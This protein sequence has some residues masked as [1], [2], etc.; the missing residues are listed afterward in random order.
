[1][2]CNDI[3]I[4]KDKLEV[5]FHLVNAYNI[6]KEEKI[7]ALKDII[8][9]TQYG[10]FSKDNLDKI[11]N[12]YYLHSQYS[13]N[14][15]NYPIIKC[16]KFEDTELILLMIEKGLDLEMESKYFKNKLFYQPFDNKLPVK[17]FIDDYFT[18]IRKI[19]KEES[20]YLLSLLNNN[21][22]KINKNENSFIETLSAISYHIPFYSGDYA[23]ILSKQNSESI[24]EHFLFN[25]H[26]S[27]NIKIDKIIS[28][29]LEEGNL[30]VILSILKNEST[31]NMVIESPSFS[32]VNIFIKPLSNFKKKSYSNKTRINEFLKDEIEHN[33]LAILDNGCLDKVD[34]SKNCEINGTNVGHIGFVIFNKIDCFETTIKNKKIIGKILNKL[35]NIDYPNSEGESLLLHAVRKYSNIK[36]AEAL[37]EYGA[38]L[39]FK[40]KQGNN[41][42]NSHNQTHK[43]M[44]INLEKEL[45]LSATENF[46]N[47]NDH[48][49]NKRI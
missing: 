15:E 27:S 42:F 25:N 34:F 40:D 19:K 32:L 31:R 29:S 41:I 44:I 1:M 14:T 2:E 39:H 46:N 48:K 30:S 43:S 22:H 13:S 26:D 35:P 24:S 36:I 5:I 21:I 33:I 47:K 23:K 17:I 45:I 18:K 28:N 38:D 16:M 6:S 12:I 4:D 11:D 49:K 9:T 10:I 37:I 8:K 3:M 20:S 7:T